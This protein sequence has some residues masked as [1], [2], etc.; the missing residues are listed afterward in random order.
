MHQLLLG[1]DGFYDD[2]FRSLR[3][4]YEPVRWVPDQQASHEGDLD[5][6]T[7]VNELIHAYRV[8]GT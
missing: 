8:R 1:E 6:A 4:P 7:R 2:V 5:K 3:I